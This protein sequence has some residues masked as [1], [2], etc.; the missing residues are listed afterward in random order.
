MR[1][2][3]CGLPEPGLG[4]MV[5]YDKDVKKADRAAGL[6]SQAAFFGVL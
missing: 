5:L 1:G 2:R 6:L 4:G 3:F